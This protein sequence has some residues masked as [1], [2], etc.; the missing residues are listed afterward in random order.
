MPVKGVDYVFHQAALRI[1][2]YAE[3]PREAVQGLMD[4]TSNVLESS[5]HHKIK[6]N[7]AAS[8]DSVYSDPTYF[9]CMKVTHLTIGHFMVLARS[10]TNKW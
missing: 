8:S 5:V 2:R 1:T 4:G 10:L 9:Q 7:A 3:E 6:K